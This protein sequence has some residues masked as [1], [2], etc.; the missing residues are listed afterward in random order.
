MQSRDSQGVAIDASQDIY[1]VTFTRSDDGD[2]EQYSETVSQYLSNG[3]YYA[4]VTPTVASTY[5]VTVHMTNDYTASDPSVPTEI[6][7]SPFTVIV[8]PYPVS[9]PLSYFVTGETSCVSYI[10]QT[11]TV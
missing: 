4:S 9:A 5:Y 8:E 10:S 7:G 3:F 2:S 6:S 1:G 11:V